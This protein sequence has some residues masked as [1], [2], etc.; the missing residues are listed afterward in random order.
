M[1]VGEAMAEVIDDG[2]RS[3]GLARGCSK[4]GHE[5]SE[6]MCAKVIGDWWRFE[7]EMLRIGAHGGNG[8][9]GVFAWVLGSNGV[10]R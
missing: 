3:F 6:K 2:Q 4:W 10:G 1:K 8:N 7:Q 9:G 5:C